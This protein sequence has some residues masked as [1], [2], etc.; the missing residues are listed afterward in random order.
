MC[1]SFF[2][3][4]V[5]RLRLMMCASQTKLFSF[6]TER[7][8]VEENE[9]KST[10]SIIHPSSIFW[11]FQVML[12]LLLLLLPAAI[13]IVQFY[14]S[15]SFF[16]DVVM[17]AFLTRWILLCCS[18]SVAVVAVDLICMHSN[19]TIESNEAYKRTNKLMHSK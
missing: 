8:N 4:W 3:L 14:I 18:C 13:I 10:K 5:C 16:L 6:E 12:L 7:S 15:F 9:N 11:Y 17:Y 2:R 1:F 19:E